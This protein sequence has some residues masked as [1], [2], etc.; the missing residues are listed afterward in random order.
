VADI[1]PV[2]GIGA[3]AGGLDAF[4]KFFS[5]VP[6]ES[7]FA[8]VVIQHLAPRHVSI[9]CTLI[10]RSTLMPVHEAQTGVAPEA[11]HVYVITPGLEPRRHQDVWVFTG[12]HLKRTFTFKASGRVS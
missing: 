4:E 7:G 1:V 8:F 12:T 3:S 5:H 9:L 6:V 10:A 11:N 2:V